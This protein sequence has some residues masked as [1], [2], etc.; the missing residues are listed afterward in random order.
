MYFTLRR[1]MTRIQWSIVIAIA[2]EGKVYEPYG[3]AFMKK[4]GFTNSSTIRR[5][6]EKLSRT[7]VIFNSSDDEG[8]YFEIDDVFF[9]KWVTNTH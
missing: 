3:K 5:V 8:D 7:G 9:Q 1:I 4:Y 6:I 2:K